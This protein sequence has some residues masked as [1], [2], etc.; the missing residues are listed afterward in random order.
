MKEKSKGT[1]SIQFILGTTFFV[2]V[3]IFSIMILVV[4][5][6][7]Y[8]SYMYKKELYLEGLR[9]IDNFYS[10]AYLPNNTLNST[11][12]NMIQRCES[13][14]FFD[15]TIG[16]NRE[17]IQLVNM[18]SKE[19]INSMS[20]KREIYLVLYAPYMYNFTSHIGKFNHTIEIRIERKDSEHPYE[21]LYFDNKYYRS[22]DLINYKNKTFILDYIDKDGYVAFL[23]TN[24]SYICGP[25]LP[26]DK[27][28]ISLS[29]YID[30][31]GY[32]E[33]YIFYI[34]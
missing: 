4:Y 18:I 33:K 19:K 10:L 26:K 22:G 31:Y 29:L 24:I 34:W 1:L 20:I 8:F 17:Y 25:K 23:K 12:F 15:P 6:F 27:E 30:R 9:I 16:I 3:V 13:S 7:K 5:S 14:P 21:Y 2:L 11:F 28:I 32:L